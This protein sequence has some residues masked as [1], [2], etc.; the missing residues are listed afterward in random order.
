MKSK[1][2]PKIV[3]LNKEQHKNIKVRDLTSFEHLQST[4]MLPVTAHEFA[5]LGAEY[6]IVFVKNTDTNEL[7]AVAL[8]SLKVGENLFVNE[9]NKW[10]GVFVPGCLG[11]HPFMLSPSNNNK[12]QLTVAL[13][14]DSPQVDE[15]EGNALFAE[16]GEETEY[17]KARKEALVSY[18]ESDRLTKVFTK[19]LNELELLTAKNITVNVGAEKVNINGLYIIDEKKLGELPE[20]K[21]AD[22]RKRGFLPVIYAQLGS[23]H[24]LS[25]L[26]KLQA[27]RPASSTVEVSQAS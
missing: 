2:S 12:D 4:H 15:A 24:Q 8:L 25:K 16:D 3:P 26:A 14:E 10:R 18:L 20:E 11:N 9:V 6:P 22:F 17:L 27:E 23:L 5:R 7:Q 19:T 21:F 13:V 1:Q